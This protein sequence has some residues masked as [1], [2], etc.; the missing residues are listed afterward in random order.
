MSNRPTPKPRPKPRPQPRPPVRRE[1][2]LTPRFTSSPVPDT[3]QAQFPNHLSPTPQFNDLY[4][5]NGP[6]SSINNLNSVAYMP[7]T[8]HNEVPTVNTTVDRSDFRYDGFKTPPLARLK[9]NMDEEHSLLRDQVFVEMQ[10][11][12][13]DKTFREIVFK[14][15]S[16]INYNVN[17]KYAFLS[18]K[19]LLKKNVVSLKVKHKVLLDYK[20]FL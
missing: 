16:F 1:E 10:R 15:A 2:I 9:F 19:D 11:N 20:Y 4:S 6:V 17:E 7:S 14:L 8:F 5:I 12:S 13:A 3:T 18:F